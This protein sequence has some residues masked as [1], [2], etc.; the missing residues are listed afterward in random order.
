MYSIVLEIAPR[1][2]T[3]WEKMRS[4]FGNEITKRECTVNDRWLR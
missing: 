2:E 3:V 1:S 4:K